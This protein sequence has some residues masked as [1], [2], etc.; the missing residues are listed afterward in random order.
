MEA[1]AT[2]R[3]VQS[4]LAT[5]VVSVIG[6][7]AIAFH[8]ERHD[9]PS[10]VAP[11]YIV[12]ADFD[13]DDHLDL[14]VAIFSGTEVALF[15]GNGQGAFTQA[16]IAPVGIGPWGMVAADLNGDSHPDLAVTNVESNDVAILLG[17]GALGFTA[18]PL[19]AVEPACHA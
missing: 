3:G 4:F 19:V 6:S 2:R 16:G 10:G 17:N 18:Q 12:A 8:F 14:A 11:V 15:K 7:E 5:A 13:Q 1:L 9:H